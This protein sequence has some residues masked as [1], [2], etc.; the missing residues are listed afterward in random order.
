[1]AAVSA[2]LWPDILKKKKKKDFPSD[3]YVLTQRSM[4]ITFS[5]KVYLK[6]ATKHATEGHRYFISLLILQF[7]AGLWQAFERHFYA[8]LFSHIKT[9]KLSRHSLR[10]HISVVTKG[11]QTSETYRVRHSFTESISMLKRTY[12]FGLRKIYTRLPSSVHSWHG[13]QH[14]KWTRHIWENRCKW[15][16]S[17]KSHLHFGECLA[18]VWKA[19][20]Y[21]S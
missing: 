6:I 11:W 8:K 7:S 4:N 2:G 12:K 14:L 5:C 9:F 10:I 13:Q 20:M 15:S 21:R 1:M 19:K 3:E 16:L 17:I 18:S